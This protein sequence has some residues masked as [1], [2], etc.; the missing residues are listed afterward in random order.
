[1]RVLVPT[2]RGGLD[3]VVAGMFARAPTFTIVEVSDGTITNVRVVPNPASSA[4][5]GAG[6]TATQFCIDEGVDVVL[7]PQFG[8]NALGALQAAGIKLYQVNPGTPVRNA[9]EALLRGEL[10]TAS[11]PQEET[12]PGYGPG[13]GRGMGRGIGRGRRRGGGWGR[14]RG[15][16]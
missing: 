6:V 9:V 11:V 16:W 3:D 12:G 13:T 10:P 5:R 15:G 4:P 14:G 1:M 7:A 8:P 2:T